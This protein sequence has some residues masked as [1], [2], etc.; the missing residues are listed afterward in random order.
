MIELRGVRFAYEKGR[1]VLDD[2]S[3]DIARGES[4]GL[5]GANGAGKST[6]MKA[7]LG[8]VTVRGRVAVDGLEMNRGN[9]SGIR[10]RLGFVLQNSDN[11]MFMPTVYEDMMSDRQSR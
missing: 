11:Q 7:L 4:V 2:V 8:L 6:L 1:D 3:F 5:I 9:L 10:R